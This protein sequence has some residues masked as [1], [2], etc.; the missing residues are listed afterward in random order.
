MPA[1]NNSLGNLCFL[2]VKI[3]NF[4][5]APG[6]ELFITAIK[7]QFISVKSFKFLCLFESIAHR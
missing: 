5:P 3:E 1:T 4:T 6:F 2:P 7:I